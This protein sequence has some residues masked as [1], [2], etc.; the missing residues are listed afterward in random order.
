MPVAIGF[1][2]CSLSLRTE[3]KMTQT[4]FAAAAHVSFASSNGCVNTIFDERPDDTVC[5]QYEIYM[6]DRRK[7]AL[8]KKGA[9]YD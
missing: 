5:R 2:S 1:A 9:N 7:V 4:D 8:E 6:N 3:L